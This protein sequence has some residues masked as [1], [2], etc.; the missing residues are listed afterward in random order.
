MRKSDHAYAKATAPTLDVT[1]ERTPLARIAAEGRRVK[2][3]RQHPIGPYVVDF[4]CAGAK[5]AVEIDG[6]AHDMD[7]G[8]EHDAKRDEFLREQGIATLG[9]ISFKLKHHLDSLRLRHSP[10]PREG[11][12]PE[13]RAPRRQRWIPAFAGM[14]DPV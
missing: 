7:D 9:R 1:S 11:G 2:I 10:R 13:R 12:G 5:L 14:R 6:I 3:R 8:P 4:Y